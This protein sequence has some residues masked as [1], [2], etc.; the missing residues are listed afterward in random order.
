[1]NEVN[2]TINKFLYPFLQRI[3]DLN[4]VAIYISGESNLVVVISTYLAL[5][6]LFYV[7]IFSPSTTHIVD[8]HSVRVN[9]FPISVDR[10]FTQ[11]DQGTIPIQPLL[12]LCRS[13][14]RQTLPSNLH[15][16]NVLPVHP[17]SKA[18]NKSYLLWLDFCTENTIFINYMVVSYSLSYHFIDIVDE[19]M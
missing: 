18:T 16:S 10:F 5:I 12:F 17:P 14:T 7:I 8:V 4:L 3:I 9:W 11:Y 2:K 1:M 6:V 15:T 13:I 19:V